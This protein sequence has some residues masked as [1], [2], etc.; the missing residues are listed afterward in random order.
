MSKESLLAFARGEEFKQSYITVYDVSGDG[1]IRIHSCDRCTGLTDNGLLIQV[2]ETKEDVMTSVPEE[3]IH[4]A[5]MAYL[6]GE[7]VLTI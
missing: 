2:C 6:N 5:A 7:K 3:E 4:E 1:V